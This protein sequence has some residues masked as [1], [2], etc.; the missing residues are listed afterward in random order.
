MTNNSDNQAK[1]S[2][3]YAKTNGHLLIKFDD[4]GDLFQKGALCIKYS[5]DDTISFINRQDSPVILYWLYNEIATYL[6]CTR[7]YIHCNGIF[8]PT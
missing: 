7:I 5:G 2:L 6:E 3:D 4:N 1:L 8:T